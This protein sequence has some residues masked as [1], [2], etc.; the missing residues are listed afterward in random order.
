MNVSS[1]NSKY[2][3]IIGKAKATVIFFQHPTLQ[4]YKRKTS[5]GINCASTIHFRKNV[6]TMLKKQKQI[7]SSCCSHSLGNRFLLNEVI[8][9]S[10]EHYTVVIVES[11]TETSSDTQI[12]RLGAAVS[13]WPPDLRPAQ[14]LERERDRDMDLE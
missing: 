8:N 14:D 2:K 11:Y 13:Q 5:S 9:A 1:A 10:S 3:N 6:Y 7:L 4:M 12:E